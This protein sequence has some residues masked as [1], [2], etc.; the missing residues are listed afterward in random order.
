M[1]FKNDRLQASS[2]RREW[3]GVDKYSQRMERWSPKPTDDPV[4][5][6]LEGL[7][8]RARAGEI[9]SL[10]ERI[11]DV[12]PQAR[13]ILDLP[14]AEVVAE[15]PWWSDATFRSWGLA[16]EGDVRGQRRRALISPRQV[17]IAN[18]VEAFRIVMLRRR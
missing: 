9:R 10:L 15:G 8:E 5:C 1:L 11:H 12:T 7:W 6:V 17:L 16:V 14:G 4:V 2:W 3:A 18:G 13:V